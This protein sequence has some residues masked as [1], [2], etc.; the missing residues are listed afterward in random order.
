MPPKPAL[1]VKPMIGNR[2]NPLT[3]KLKV[4]NEKDL[5]NNALSVLQNR[6]SKNDKSAIRYLYILLNY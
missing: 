5:V 4:D 2:P 6:S 1:P 3:A